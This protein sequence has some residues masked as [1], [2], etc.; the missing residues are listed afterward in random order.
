MKTLVRKSLILVWFVVVVVFTFSSCSVERIQSTAKPRTPFVSADYNHFQG[1]VLFPDLDEGLDVL[2][3]A[4]FHGHRPVKEN[5]GFFTDGG[6]LILPNEHNTISTGRLSALPIKIYNSTLYVLHK[7]Q[8]LEVLGIIHTHIDP[9]AANTPSTRNDYQFGYLGIHNYV[10]SY[11]E[12]FDAYKDESGEETYKSIGSR[13]DYTII[14]AR[15]LR[16]NTPAL[17]QVH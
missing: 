4:G 16:E 13:S 17:A 1:G 9:Y 7:E 8:L 10:I 12:I 15:L 11:H 14:K 6:L 2:W 5:V 3:R